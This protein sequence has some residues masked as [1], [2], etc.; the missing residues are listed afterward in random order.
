MGEQKGPIVVPRPGAAERTRAYSLAR[1]LCSEAE[2]LHLTL[3]TLAQQRRGLAE[4][5]TDAIWKDLSWAELDNCSSG[6]TAA[7]KVNRQLYC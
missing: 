3:A 5:S 2:S 1:Q 7:L 6:L 4:K